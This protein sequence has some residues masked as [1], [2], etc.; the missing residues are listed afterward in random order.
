M[1][2]NGRRLALRKHNKL[3]IYAEWKNYI[4]G[5]A[6]KFYV[7]GKFPRINKYVSLHRLELRCIK[8]ITDVPVVL[9]C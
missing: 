2:I 1:K 3:Q 8:V 9:Y 7:V 4:I 6:K 5:S